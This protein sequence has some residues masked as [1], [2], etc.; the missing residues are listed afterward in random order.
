VTRGPLGPISP[1]RRRA[2]VKPFQHRARPLVLV[3]GVLSEQRRDDVTQ[4][5]YVAWMAEPR[6]CPA[7]ASPN[8]A[9][10]GECFGGLWCLE[11]R[12]E[13]R[14]TRFPSGPDPAWWTLRG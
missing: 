3:N 11:C 2:R 8:V 6:A 13:W 5:Q 9:V 1:P 12:H 10:D 7:C 4:A 14:V